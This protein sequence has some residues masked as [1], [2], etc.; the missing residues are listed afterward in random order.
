MF[1][2]KAY[3]FT[4]TIFIVCSFHIGGFAQ[5]INNFPYRQDFEESNGNWTTGGSA[6]DWSWGMPSKSVINKAGSGTKC[7]I[8]GNLSGNFYNDNES[9][10]LQSPCFDFSNITLPYISFFVNWDTE[11]SYDG[12]ALQY[13]DNNGLSWQ[14]VGAYNDASDCLNSAWYNTGNIRY[15]VQ[16]PGWSGTGN[17]GSNG[18]LQ[19]QHTMPYLAGKPNVLFRFVFGAGKIENNFNGFAVDDILVDE[20]PNSGQ[21]SFFY[22]C[23][24]GRE[25]LFTPLPAN[26]IHSP[27]WNFGDPASGNSNT[28]DGN[29]AANH[30]FS[31]SGTFTIT[32]SANGA[33]GETVSSDIRLIIPEAAATITT[34]IT[35]NGATGVVS[36]TL[37]N[38]TARA[39]FVWNTTPAL[40]TASANVK[41]GTYTVNV[42]V[43]GGC[44]A[45]STVSI[46]EPPALQH[47]VNISEPDCSNQNGS[48]SITQS[49]G[50]LPYSFN[51]SPSVSASASASSLE[52][53]DYV[54]TVSDKNQCTDTVTRT[55]IPAPGNLSHTVAT[56]LPDCG[57]KNGSITIT[58]KGGSPPYHYAWLP[59]QNFAESA[60]GLAEG[61]YEIHVTDAIGCLDTL[62]VTLGSKA[63]SFSLGKDTVL[64]SGEHLLLQ[65]P[66]GYAKYLWNDGTQTSSKDIQTEGNYILT[67]TND[68]GC[69]ASD[70][71]H[72]F[73]G[74]GDIV[75]PSGITPNGDFKNDVF[76][77][78]GGLSQISAYKIIHL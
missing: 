17:N 71:I 47:T 34:P 72:I 43:E 15:G 53:G 65:A 7:W 36:A 24:P 52:G 8:T 26:C 14:S 32:L 58:E 39:E 45:T 48:I 55:L 62:S 60:Y 18:W 56:V 49:G 67:V 73:S 76:G 61:H 68:G 9:S 46:D 21:P 51:W 28:A 5:C 75:F 20:A 66:S 4:I 3:Y 13:S 77:P 57:I 35:C 6:S 38:S 44:S 63:F 27:I 42:S 12:A 40:N 11:Y 25:V 1:L 41:A 59:E 37:T 78:I 19:A 23:G 29:S 22:T 30:V 16:A 50:V 33:N 70:T 10:W 74:C 31:T 2:S 64:C 69:I 54:I